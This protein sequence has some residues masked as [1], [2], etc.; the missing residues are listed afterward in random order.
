MI[1]NTLFDIPITEVDSARSSK[2]APNSDAKKKI[3]TTFETSLKELIPELHNART[4][5]QTFARLVRCCDTSWE[6]GVAPLRQELIKLSRRWNEIGPPISCPYRPSPEELSRHKEEA[7]GFEYYQKLNIV[8]SRVI[9]SSLDGW[10]P[11]GDWKAAKDLNS[12]LFKQWL[13]ASVEADGP[14]LNEEQIKSQWPFDVDID[15]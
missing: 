9:G 1:S 13:K 8:L 5:D 11:H 12:L 3:T 14:V 2:E 7:E 6:D 4:F 10:V 15:D